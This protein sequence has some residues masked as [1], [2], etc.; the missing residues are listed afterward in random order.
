MLATE[1][2]LG[3]IPH[4]RSRYESILRGCLYRD[5][6]ERVYIS[7]QKPFCTFAGVGYTPVTRTSARLP[8]T[9]NAITEPRAGRRLDANAMEL[10]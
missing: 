2:T 9:S 8:S 6:P 5:L 7:E 3:L 10:Q 4:F 1:A